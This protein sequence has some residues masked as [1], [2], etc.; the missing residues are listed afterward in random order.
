[1][2]KTSKLITTTEFNELNVTTDSSWTQVEDKIYSKV[3]FPKDWHTYLLY[4]HKP[5]VI[6]VSISG[7][8]GRIHTERLQ[9]MCAWLTARHRKK[10]KKYRNHR[11]YIQKI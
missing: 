2:K 11:F 5:E 7:L 6:L 9:L 10:L 8:T 1:M 4:E 3:V